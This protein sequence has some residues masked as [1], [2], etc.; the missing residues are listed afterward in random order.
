M[1]VACAAS[2]LR[3]RRALGCDLVFIIEGEEES[4]SAGFEDAVKRHKVRSCF[5]PI[6][7]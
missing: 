3:R 4:G 7:N 6:S 5:H 1:A 2:E